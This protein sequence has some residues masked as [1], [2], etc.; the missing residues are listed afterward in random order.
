MQSSPPGVGMLTNMATEP[1]PFV[2]QE[3][4][5]RHFTITDE[6]VRSYVAG[7]EMDPPPTVPCMLAN[8]A[9][10]G[11]RVL[12]PNHFGHLWLRQEWEFHQPL[13]RGTEYGVH[14]RV[15]DIYD[16]RDRRVLLTETAMCEPS[17]DVAVRQRH[18]Q[19]FLLN[20]SGGELKLRDASSKEGARNFVVPQ[21]KE[22]SP[23]ERTISLE[24]CGQF[25]HGNA[26]YHTDRAE[27]QRL[28]FRDVVVGGA[29]TMGY[30]GMLL[31]R[32]FGA[33]WQT[34]GRLLVK[35]TNPVWASETVR[36][37]CVVKT[38]E[39][40][41]SLSMGIFAWVEKDDG[42]VV[43]VATGGLAASTSDG[44]VGDEPSGPLRAS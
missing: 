29:M 13:Q 25:F 10:S 39:D 28:G 23:I 17:G 9:D 26:S 11:G 36:A 14:G 41:P 27:S 44:E 12:L 16:R 35:F 42:T 38:A 21:G 33:E 1:E 7:L 18:H 31:D 30:L 40:D 43:V 37:R 2:G 24:M 4:R 5:P 34:K 8:Q 6:L 19:S 15:A 22:L 20:Q 3:L 32:E